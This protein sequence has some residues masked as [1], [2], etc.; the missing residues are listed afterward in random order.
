MPL[1][2]RNHTMEYKVFLKLPLFIFNIEYS[3][4]YRISSR[5][6]FIVSSKM[7]GGNLIFLHISFVQS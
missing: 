6:M 3:L 5:L 2:Q 1:T 7:N 4:F